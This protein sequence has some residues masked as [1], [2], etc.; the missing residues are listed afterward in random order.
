MTK[1]NNTQ[2]ANHRYGEGSFDREGTIRQIYQSVRE[3]QNEAPCERTSSVHQLPEIRPPCQDL[4]FGSPDLQIMRRKTLLPPIQGQ[5]TTAT[6]MCKLR[7]GDEKKAKTGLASKRTTHKQD[8]RNS[9]PYITGN[10]WATLTVHKLE[11]RPFSCQPYI[12]ITT[13][14]T[15]EQPMELSTKQ[16]EPTARNLIPKTSDRGAKVV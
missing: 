1:W 16:S 4:Q 15:I 9:A 3:L 11:K 2:L 5:Q 10:A 14:A 8:S 7:I 6:Q 13:P 12:P